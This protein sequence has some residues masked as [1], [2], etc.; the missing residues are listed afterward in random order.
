MKCFTNLLFILAW[1][2]ACFHFVRSEHSYVG[3]TDIDIKTC[4]KITG[5]FRIRST[6]VLEGLEEKMPDNK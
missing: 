5:N 6:D 4:S 2:H 3:A 1:D